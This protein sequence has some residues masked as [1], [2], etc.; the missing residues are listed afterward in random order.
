MLRR[1]SAGLLAT[2]AFVAPLAATAQEGS[3]EHLDNV[4]AFDSEARDQPNIPNIGLCD[5]LRGDDRQWED[6]FIVNIRSWRLTVR[7]LK[8]FHAG[9]ITFLE[10]M[11]PKKD[12]ITQ[13]KLVSSTVPL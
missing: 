8:D 9:N 11:P 1:F 12:K 10:K 6:T 3:A 5:S 4:I 2:A 7:N 13:D